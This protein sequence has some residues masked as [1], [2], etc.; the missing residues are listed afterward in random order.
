MA[1]VGSTR[2]GPIIGDSAHSKAAA[3]KLFTHPAPQLANSDALLHRL[4]SVC[5]V[6]ACSEWQ[7]ERLISGRQAHLT[8]AL[9]FLLSGFLLLGPPSCGDFTPGKPRHALTII[10]TTGVECPLDNTIFYIGGPGDR[11]QYQR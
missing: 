4:I 9:F 8:A 6:V 3:I 10:A 7:L 1:Y 2:G 5:Y 11:C